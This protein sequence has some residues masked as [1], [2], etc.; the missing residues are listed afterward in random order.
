VGQKKPNEMNMPSKKTHSKL[1]AVA[2]TSERA[3]S[4]LSSLS[5]YLIP[6]SIVL[7]T[8]V[9]FLPTLQNGFVAWDDPEN[10]VNNTNYRGLSWSH[11]FWMFTTFHMSLYR[12][13]TWLTHGFDYLVWGMEP[14]GYHLTSLVF[15]VGNAVLVYFLSQRLLK[16]AQ[17]QSP[18]ANR[19]LR[20][21]AA[22]AALLFALHPLRVEAVAWASGRS[23]VVAAFFLLLT[24]V[25]YLK[26]V[27]LSQT[28]SLVYWKWLIL[29]WL[30][31]ALSLLGKVSG[32]MLPVLLLALD[33]YPLRR[34]PRKFNQWFR[35]ETRWIFLEKLPFAALAGATSLL[36]LM[37]KYHFDAVATL[38]DYGVISRLSQTFYGLFFYVWK[39]LLPLDLSPLYEKLSYLRRV[40]HID[41]ASACVVTAL[42]V[43]LYILRKHWPAGLACWVCYVI[44]VTPVLGIMPYG[45]QVVADRYSYVAS[46]GWSVL[47]GCGALSVWRLWDSRP[48][49]NRLVM[50]FNAVSA[51]LLITLGFLTWRQTHVWHDSERIWKQAVKVDPQSSLARMYWG[52]ELVRQ[53]KFDQGIEQLRLAVR[54]DPSSYDTHNTLGYA[55]IAQGRADEAVQELQNAISIDPRRP[56]AQN[57]LGNA[58]ANRGDLNE[59]VDH[60]MTA[61]RAAPEQADGYYN[62]ARVLA[63][64]NK[65]NEAIENYHLALRRKAR[66]SD[67]HNNLGLL[68]WRENRLDEAYA[69]FHEALKDDPTY[70]KAHFNLGRLH[71]QTGKHSEAIQS[72]ETALRLQPGVPEIHEG[73]ARVLEARGDKQEAVWHRRQ[74]L[75]ILESS[76]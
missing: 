61:I 7:A 36:A 29:A 1:S 15:H 9:A 26:A 20:I 37:A 2:W 55:L 71:A 76:R 19:V 59:A 25:C 6:G 23:D 35:T 42:T 18:P 62:L 49:H 33:Y 69:E 28:R 39:T 72:F 52:L 5:V 65:I 53:R 66:D 12:P 70:A 8:L 14:I 56:G 10:F 73:L 16:M 58:L 54:L 67:T 57:N 48:S 30:N 41:I 27:E 17:G 34:L 46:V 45:P 31:F 60:F 24:M 4:R 21:G 43:L 44:L 63:E 68:Y 51:M 38:E 22:F 3:P 64:Q 50:I 13:L 40:N 47:A 32:I 11:I 75:A 74:A